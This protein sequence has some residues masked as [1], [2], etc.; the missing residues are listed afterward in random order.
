MSPEAQ[1]A[2]PETLHPFTWTAVSTC[3]GENAGAQ[4]PGS[5]MDNSI[6]A[7]SAQSEYA[8]KTLKK[9][10]S[11]PGKHVI[12][13][14]THSIS[15]FLSINLALCPLPTPAASPLPSLPSPSPSPRL[16]HLRSPVVTFLHI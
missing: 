14:T 5:N 4:A 7:K 10:P 12:F 16:C 2:A 13:Q 11:G 15:V 9:L 3:I 6:R 1:A 8:S